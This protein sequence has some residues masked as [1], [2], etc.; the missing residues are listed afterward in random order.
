M[1]IIIKKL[2]TYIIKTRNIHKCKFG[3]SVLLRGACH[4][5]GKNH[6]GNRSLFY[7]SSM[8]YASYMGDQNVFV[9]VKIGKYCSLGSDIAVVA[10]THP[11]NNMVSTPVSYT[12]LYKQTPLKKC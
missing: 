3:S 12:H 9:N 11:L 4:F 6:I 1:K 5:E 2:L 8:G 7:N 10:S